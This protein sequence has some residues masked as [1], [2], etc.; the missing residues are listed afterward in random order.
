MTPHV[1]GEG[2][3]DRRKH[4]RVAFPYLL[5]MTP[6]DA[7]GETNGDEVVVVGKELT[8]KGLGVYHEH[9]FPYRRAT[10]TL[11]HPQAGYFVAEVDISWCR[12]TE[13]GWYESGGRIVQWIETGTACPLSQTA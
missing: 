8:E 13:T 7:S 2:R 6:I 3:R 11:N 5:R 1:R 12:F 4:Q 10:V 9:P